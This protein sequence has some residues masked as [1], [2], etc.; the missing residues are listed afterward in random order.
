MKEFLKRNQFL[1]INLAVAI[2]LGIGAVQERLKNWQAEGLDFVE[3][4]FAIHNIILLSVV[5]FRQDQ[6]AIE[7]KIF[8]QIVALVAFCSGIA[9]V[10][11]PAVDASFPLA[12]K[13]VLFVGIFLGAATML[14]LGKSFGILISLRTV[15]KKGFYGIIR[16][17]M[18]FTDIIMRIG[19]VLKNG[20]TVNLVILFVSTTC[21]VY[22]AIL[23]ERFLAQF[24]E[25]QEYMNEVKYR[26]IP[27]IF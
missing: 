26:F 7:T 27:G 24:Q 25:Y 21:Y 12:A 14:N 6:K 1:L 13:G 9:L 5:L 22:R 11:T 16:H 23:E 15:K 3:A 17:P 18:Y 2:F 19:Y 20:C 4:A 8:P 10:R